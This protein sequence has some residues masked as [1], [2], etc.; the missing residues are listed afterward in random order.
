MLPL[1]STSCVVLLATIGAAQPENKQLL[2]DVVLAEQ[3]AVNSSIE[4]GRYYD[5]VI[6]KSIV[7]RISSNFTSGTCFNVAETFSPSSYP[8]DTITEFE[9]ITSS[10]W[11]LNPL[12]QSTLQ[13]VGLNLYSPEANYSH[14]EVNFRW[15]EESIATNEFVLKAFAGDQCEDDAT[16]PWF[17]WGQCGEED[18]GAHCNELPYNVKSLRVERMIPGNDTQC[19]IAAERG[20]GAKV[21][22]AGIVAIFGGIVVAG[23]MAV[24]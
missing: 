11:P 12:C 22:R 5:D 4:C 7:M 15:Y 17:S 23:V 2:A 6:P 8:N 14:V 10:C 13:A 3:S 20:A 1:R 9:G 18:A 19:M 16:E 24:V 21:G